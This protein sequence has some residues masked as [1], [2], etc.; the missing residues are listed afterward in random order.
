MIRASRFEAFI[1]P[2]FFLCLSSACSTPGAFKPSAV[3]PGMVLIPGGTVTMGCA[4]DDKECYGDDQPLHS[5]VLGPFYLD[6]AEVT[7]RAF[8]AC[9]DAGRCATP[10]TKS[11][12]N[13]CKWGWEGREDDPV[14][15]INWEQALAYCRW[16]GKRLPSSAEFE[17]AAG[18]HD[19]D[20]LWDWTGDCHRNNQNVASEGQAGGA[21]TCE[22]MIV[23]HFSKSIREKS[24]R[25]SEP[26]LA[27]PTLSNTG[28]G[29]RCARSAE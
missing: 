12:L 17:Y 3:P 14:N 10:K 20:G 24:K 16:S 25:N 5:V 6:E 19:L 13:A 1:L 15:C 28:I 21:G 2:A 29:I 27:A 9:V 22:E 23:R 7:V 26:G 18:S 4:G 8:H 11:K